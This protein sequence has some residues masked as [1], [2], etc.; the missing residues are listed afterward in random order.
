MCR[1]RKSAG[2]YVL[3][4]CETIAR[5]VERKAALEKI[6]RFRL[7]RHKPQAPSLK[8]LSEIPLPDNSVDLAVIGSM[9]DLQ[10]AD[11][12]LVIQELQRVAAN[13]L[14]I[15]NSPLSQPLAET[16][17]TDAG[18]R[19]DSVDVSGL[20]PRRCWWRTLAVRPPA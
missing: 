19:P 6:R 9:P 4:P 12:R 15:E 3:E 20:G 7:V 1:C 17:L 13:V 2:I 8:P 16:P 18:F 5:Y 11:C 14:L 10:T